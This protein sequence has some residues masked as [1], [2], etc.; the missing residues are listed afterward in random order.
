MKAIHADPREVRKLFT[1]R[2]TIPDFQRPYSWELEHCERLWEDILAFYNQKTTGSDRYFLGNMV[3]HYLDNEFAVID[4]Q[5]RLTTL[6]LLIKALHQKAGTVKALEECLKMKN[7]LTSELTDE[8]RVESNVIE[9][10]KKSLA[11]II[12]NNGRSLPEDSK[13][14]VN[15]QYFNKAIEQWWNDQG[16]NP[17]KLTGLILTVLDQVV[18]LPIHCGSEDD[19]LTIFETINNRGMSL[20]DADIFKAKIYHKVD[21]EKEDFV[22]RWNALNNHEWLF[23]NYMH[24][25][26]ASEND[27]TKEIALRSFFAQKGRLQ[28]PWAQII[29]SL[30]IIDVVYDSLHLSDWSTVGWRIL[31]TYPNYYWTFPLCVFL[32]K[33]GRFDSTGSFVLTKGDT[34]K[35]EEL[36]SESIKF[37]FTKGVVHNSVNAVRDVV[38]RVCALIH[39]DGNYV[40]EFKNGYLSDAKEFE[41]KI[42]D[43]QYGR[44][45][46]GLVVICAALNPA[47]DMEAFKDM[48][49][50]N[51]HIEHIL[52]KKWNDYDGWTA[53]TWE[54]SLNSLGNLTPLEWNLN[55]SAKNEYFQRKK[56]KYSL[57]AV[58]DALDLI[59]VDE[60]T[61]KSCTTR[62]EQSRQRI[63]D[64]ICH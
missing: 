31:E 39:S 24:V 17:D 52:P 32:H 41:R 50:S 57:S 36:I 45:L 18:L 29:E 23:R 21:G 54:G 51:W 38:F 28:K 55:I 47:Q 4:G 8:L 49:S 37:F 35:Y 61:I 5:Q 1:E 48:L 2:Y 20:N 58:Q 46:R 14:K 63:L 7:P 56:H 11:D 34:I 64:F 12:F 15:Y 44:C 60:W 13:I 25:L 19:A 22:N 26:R 59:G 30:E 42:M 40:E 6:L 53:E 33:Y 10:D 16:N 3:I 27:V 43:M 9:G 62:D